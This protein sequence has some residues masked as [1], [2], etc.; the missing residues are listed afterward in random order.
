MIV[1]D[2]LKQEIEH[3]HYSN[4]FLK[5]YKAKLT[6]IHVNMLYYVHKNYSDFDSTIF[7]APF[8]I[9]KLFQTYGYLFS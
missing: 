7:N 1:N 6:N 5:N 3:I 8:I 4:L 9:I 2:T